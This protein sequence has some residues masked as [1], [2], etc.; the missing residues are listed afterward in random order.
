MQA[1]H[2]Q[3]GMLYCERCGNTLPPLTGHVF[4]A[5]AKSNRLCTRWRRDRHSS[6]KQVANTLLINCFARCAFSL[7]AHAPV[8]M[9]FQCVTVPCLP[10][11]QT[12]LRPSSAHPLKMRPPRRQMCEPHNSSKWLP[13][14]TIQ[15]YKRVQ[16]FYPRTLCFTTGTQ[17]AQVLGHE[18]NADLARGPGLLVNKHIFDG[19]PLGVLPD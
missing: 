13:R 17:N 14:R 7:C 8:A 2:Y 11:R 15:S 3:V 10:R 4:P 5:A 6:C 16:D 1:S 18:S 19:F 9:Q 12:T